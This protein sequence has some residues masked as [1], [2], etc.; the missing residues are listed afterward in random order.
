MSV[1][2][3]RFPPW[4]AMRPNEPRSSQISVTSG[5]SS[6]DRSTS[7]GSCRLCGMPT[8]RPRPRRHLER[9]AAAERIGEPVAD[10]ERPVRHEASDRGD[11]EVEALKASRK[12]TTAAHTTVSDPVEVGHQVVLEPGQEVEPGDQHDGEHADA[13]GVAS[14]IQLETA[15]WKVSNW[16]TS[17]FGRRD[18]LGFGSPRRRS[19]SG[20]CRR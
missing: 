19:R 8:G 4:N 1:V 7:D 17:R 14:T 13:F 2:R 9:D 15:A 20:R 18:H 11:Q 10:A 3:S 16:S 5:R 12:S 6:S